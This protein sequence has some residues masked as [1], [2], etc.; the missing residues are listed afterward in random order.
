MRR[1]NLTCPEKSPGQSPTWK[2][3]EENG[4][5]VRKKGKRGIDWWRYQQVILK[6]KLIPFAQECALTRPEICVQ[7]DKALSH[8]SHHQK[9][10]FLDA[11]VLRLMW[12]GNSP[13]LNVIE[14]CWFWMKHQTTKKGAP[15]DRITA[16]T[17]WKKAWEDLEQWQIQR[18]IERIPRHIQKIIELEGS[19]EYREGREDHDSC[20]PRSSQRQR[21][22][23][24]NPAGQV[25]Q[26]PEPLSPKS[27]SSRPVTATATRARAHRG[28]RPRGDSSEVVI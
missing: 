14:P 16:R 22:S 20:S 24:L 4:A 15:R 26:R 10:I 9:Q 25:S 13:D 17:V 21:Q 18:W 6:P 23:A 12:P 19:N 28:G 1:M 11:N 5:V 7:E 2:F 8:A 3:T 27:P